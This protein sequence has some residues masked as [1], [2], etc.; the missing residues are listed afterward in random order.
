MVTTTTGDEDEG[1]GIV[2]AA[3]SVASPG[4]TSV[5][6]SEGAGAARGDGGG[7][8]SSA[9]FS[10]AQ[11]CWYHGILSRAWPFA[12]LATPFA[13]FPAALEAL[14]CSE[15]CGQYALLT[16]PQTI[17]EVPATSTSAKGSGKSGSVPSN[18]ASRI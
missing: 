16:M 6:S 10:V 13:P 9:A 15:C 2:A 4:A 12:P 7:G 11:D 1:T 18:L 14:S 17:W 5:P 3:A 8:G